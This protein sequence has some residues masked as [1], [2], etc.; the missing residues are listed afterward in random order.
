MSELR[1]KIENMSFDL[2]F[3]DIKF[4]KSTERDKS[5][6]LLFKSYIPAEYEQNT[7][8]IAVSEYYPC[9]NKS[10][11]ASRELV[12]RLKESGIN[13]E[14]VV[15]IK[16]KDLA[17]RCG[18]VTGLNSLYYHE[19]YGSYVCIQAIY[20]FV[21][22]PFDEEKENAACQKCYS[23]IK[24]CPTHAI[25]KAGFTR[26][27]CLRNM[28]SGIIPT[29]HRDKVYQMTG[30][31]KCQTCCPMNN[32]RKKDPTSFDLLNVLRGEKTKELKA[33]CGSNYASRNRVIGQAICYSV[34][35][36]NKKVSEEIANLV[37][38]ESEIIRDYARW[39]MTQLT[40]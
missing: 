27:K 1:K 37:D 39:A 19:K 6:I 38:D 33:L 25:S 30:C 14:P 4:L 18:G 34:A 21:D 9:S 11:F 16:Y 5:I 29:Q 3:D 15:D 8:K 2:A 32:E 40:E 10:Y 31:D 12:K 35:K 22:V 28:M 7:G 13:S 17:R 20:V 26:Q 36:K 24:A 23:C